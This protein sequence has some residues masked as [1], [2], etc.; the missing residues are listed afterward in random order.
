[1]VVSGFTEEREPEKWRSDRKALSRPGAGRRGRARSRHVQ[2]R[3][4]EIRD[5]SQGSHTAWLCFYSRNVKKKKKKLLK[6]T[7]SCTLKF[8]NKVKNSDWNFVT[9]IYFG[10]VK[11]IVPTLSPWLLEVA[12]SH[13]L[14]M[15]TS[16]MVRNET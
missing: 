3:D 5:E 7:F 2:P 13:S 6:K 4:L 15:F 9:K 16:G 1:M 12:G 14:K 11:S 8:W 10:V